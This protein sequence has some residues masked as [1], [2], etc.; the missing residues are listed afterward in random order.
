MYRNRKKIILVGVT[1]ILVLA[2]FG[3]GAWAIVN[4]S[5]RVPQDDKI[6]SNLAGSTIYCGDTAFAY[7]QMSITDWLVYNMPRYAFLVDDGK[8]DGFIDVE[9][10]STDF[11]PANNSTVTSSD[12]MNPINENAHL[13]TMKISTDFSQEEIWTSGKHG[14]E[15][16]MLVSSTISSSSNTA[17]ISNKYWWSNESQNIKLTSDGLYDNYKHTSS[18]DT[19]IELSKKLS[20]QN[21][22]NKS[23][24]SASIKSNTGF[25][26]WNRK[27]EMENTA[28]SQASTLNYPTKVTLEYT[29]GSLSGDFSPLKQM[30]TLKTSTTKIDFKYYEI[31]YTVGTSNETIDKK[32]K[33][34]DK[35]GFQ[36]NKDGTITSNL[37]TGLDY[38]YVPISTKIFSS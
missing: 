3:V 26:Q 13:Y 33:L 8:S 31:T 10:F 2:G 25:D 32:E 11:R 15:P 1:S 36:K 20:D 17:T 38:E 16:I 18:N 21:Q 22:N 14:N 6:A 35:I 30:F 37:S 7:K 27:M 24:Y 4:S 5:N 29:S 23:T 34:L 28:Q 12:L 9:F 19:S